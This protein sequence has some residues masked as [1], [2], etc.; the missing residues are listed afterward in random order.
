M[1]QVVIDPQ[2]PDLGGNIR[3]GDARTF[4]PRL[5]RYLVERHAITSVLDVGCG[6]GHAVRFFHRLGVIAHGIDGLTTNIR[7]AVFPI[8]QHDLLSSAYVMPV[9]LVWSCEVAEHI[10]PEKVDF[11]LDTLA[12]GRIVAMTHAV[13]G[14]HGFHHVNCQPEE[15]WVERM[16]QR[17]YLLAHDNAL[18]REI[19]GRDE[20][21]N[22]F[23]ATGLVFYR[24]RG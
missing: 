6:E 16:Q 4:A 9:D 23:Q 15:Y 13:P 20:C 18:M 1:V 11:F 8:A 21:F 2:R 10:F 14:Q 24:N 12:N 5:W 17:G 22:Y 7:R 3:H 19:A